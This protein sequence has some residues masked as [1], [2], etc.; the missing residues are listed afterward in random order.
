MAGDVRGP[1]FKVCL[2]GEVGVGKTSLFYRL[3][4][5]RFHEHLGPTKGIDSC[6]KVLN[7]NGERV[8]VRQEVTRCNLNNNFAFGEIADTFML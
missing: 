3:K 2:L 8:T 7:I 5:G 6:S 4:D 1:M